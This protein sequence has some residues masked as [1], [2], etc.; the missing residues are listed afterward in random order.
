MARRSS[1]AKSDTAETQ[2]YDINRYM[3]NGKRKGYIEGDY[4]I[5]YL[6]DRSELEISPH[7]HDFHKVLFFLNGNVSYFIEGRNYDLK[8]M[9]LVMVPAGQLHRLTIHDAQD[10]E[11]LI[12]YLSPEFL[13]SV[14]EADRSLS[15]LF[16]G[17][18]EN[19]YH[20]SELSRPM[21]E[22]L[23]RLSSL[24]IDSRQSKS[25]SSEEPSKEQNQ[26]PKDASVKAP[27]FELYQRSLVMAFSIRLMSIMDGELSHSASLSSSNPVILEAL[28][29][30]NQHIKE[31]LSIDMIAEKVH[32]NRNY[33]MHLFKSE[34]GYTMHKYIT[35]K[36]LCLA[37][38]SLL[39]GVSV[40]ET[41]Y[42]AGFKDQ[43]TFYRAFKARFGV[44]PGSF[45]SESSS[46]QPRTVHTVY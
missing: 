9:D 21:Q 44:S 1:A 46:R 37:R 25:I 28:A 26:G 19:V 31:D 4:R 10:Y 18:S 29:Y 43:T 3:M 14:T 23:L 24:L 15:E 33:L 35:E 41:C 12:I 32:V 38:Q 39:S 40:T 11:R 36:R 17:L 34:T 2:K 13:L 27:F 7:Y 30:I 20:I 5:F 42:E 6:K 45:K 22:E 16:T 8:P